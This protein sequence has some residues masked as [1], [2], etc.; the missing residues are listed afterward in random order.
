[1]TI[2]GSPPLLPAFNAV[3]PPPATS[4][5]QKERNFITAIERL[6]GNTMYREA[7][8]DVAPLQVL[9]SSFF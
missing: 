7:V 5:L 4:L 2:V 6:A 3:P 8:G 1:M 9:F